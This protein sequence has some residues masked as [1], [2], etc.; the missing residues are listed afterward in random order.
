MDGDRLRRFQLVYNEAFP[1]VFTYLGRRVSDRG[2]VEDLVQETFAAAARELE[3]P[4]LE[5]VTVG[6]VIG[7]AR[8]KLADWWRKQERE[9]ARVRRW[10]S[11][12][13]APDLAE[14]AERVVET[15]T[16]LPM[17]QRA[18]LVLHYLDDLPV[19]EVADLLEK[20]VPATESLLARARHA[21]RDAYG[22]DLVDA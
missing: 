8:H 18:A 10:R 14:P 3:R 15:L 9:D 20:S 19:T 16:A 5:D 11:E 22:E 17:A 12:R 1:A 7:I 21:F 6:W 13:P 2:A 4:E